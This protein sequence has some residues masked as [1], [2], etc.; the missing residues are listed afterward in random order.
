MLLFEEQPRSMRT[1]S[2]YG[3][4]IQSAQCLQSVAPVQ[5]IAGLV[6]RS[7]KVRLQH[8]ATRCNTLQHTAT[9]CNTMQH[10][11]T[12][13]NTLQHLATH[14]SM[15]HLCKELLVLLLQS[16]ASIRCVC[17]TLPHTATHCN[18]L[19]HAATHCNALQRT[20]TH[21]NA[22]QRTAT[23][24]NRLQHTATYISGVL[25]CT[26]GWLSI[27]GCL[28]FIGHVPQKSPIISGS[29]VENNL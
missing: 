2:F 18:I 8:A 25:I 13:C 22:L 19:Q 17:N 21:Y 1:Y 23:H 28:I 6:V 20:A 3:K 26:T 9:H 4:S 16:G 15:W 24:C 27:T 11:A 5:G 14:W 10:N 29:F 12:Y 7:N